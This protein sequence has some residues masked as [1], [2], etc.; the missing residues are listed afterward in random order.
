LGDG[1]EGRMSGLAEHNESRVDER[2]SLPNNEVRVRT[3]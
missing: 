1:L 2:G 3:I